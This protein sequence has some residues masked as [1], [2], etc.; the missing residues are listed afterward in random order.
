MNQ[1][2]LSLT[3]K[4]K[5]TLRL[6]LQGY[7]A[8]SM[9]QHLGLSVH[10]INERLRDARR[11]MG[12]SSSREAARLLREAEARDPHLLGDK[13]FGD[14][15]RLPASQQERQPAQRRGTLRRAGWI[16]GGI[17]MPITAALLILSTMSGQE[18]TPAAAEPTAT[19]V[20]A[21]PASEAA[22]IAAARAF[23]A[24]C[25]HDDWGASW[26][27]THKSFQLL[28]T[29]DWWAE[30]SRGVRRDVGSAR[31][32][33]LLTVDFRPAPPNGYW[34]IKFKADYS[35]KGNA[36][37]TLSLASENGIWKVAAIS[38]E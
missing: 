11:K 33:E 2:H 32:R 25:D 9:A 34:T 4:E 26:Q 19:A 7:D 3:H 37:E 38:V 12:T 8:K 6:L 13:G 35:K 1:R 17:V 27:A 16:V 15:A 31:S 21:T 22:A 30:A 23:L 24:L 14:A 5:E 20:S 28:N 36:I 18:L 10:T 29:V